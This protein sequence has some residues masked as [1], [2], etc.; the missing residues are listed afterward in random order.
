MVLTRFAALQM[1]KRWSSVESQR[2]PSFDP[3]NVRGAPLFFRVGLWPS[4]IASGIGTVDCSQTVVNK[5]Q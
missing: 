2:L 1:P 5:P 3:T 4:I